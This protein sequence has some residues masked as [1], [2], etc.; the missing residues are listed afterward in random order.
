MRV[1]ITRLY[2][3]KNKEKKPAYINDDDDLRNYKTSRGIVGSVLPGLPGIMAPESVKDFYTKNLIGLGVVASGPIGRYAGNKKADEL[4]RKGKSDREILTR[5]TL[6]GGSIGALTGAAAGAL[7]GSVRKEPGK[8]AAIGAALGGL[9]GGYGTRA[10][11]KER[12]DK[13]KKYAD[14]S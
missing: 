5:S 3:D 9:G 2:S 13:R 7:L 11:V 12:L 14:R 10:S 8:M 4:D 6:H 1:L